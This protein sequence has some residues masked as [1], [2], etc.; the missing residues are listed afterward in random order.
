MFKP[1]Y[2]AFFSILFI[3][4]CASNPPIPDDQ[5]VESDPWENVNRKI[6]SFNDFFDQYLLVPVAKGYDFVTPKFIQARF[7]DFFKN[8]SEPWSMANNLLQLEIDDALLNLSRFIVNSTF[9]I[10]GLFDVATEVGMERNTENFGLTLAKW[11]VPKGNYIV[12]PFFGPS[13]VRQGTGS[14]VGVAAYDTYWPAKFSA[15]DDE[16]MPWNGLNRSE[17]V[18]LAVLDIVQLRADLLSLED[19][20]IGDKYTFIREAYLQRVKTQ[21]TDHIEAEDEEFDD[22]FEDEEEEDAEVAQ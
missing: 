11:G 15:Q 22:F 2:I 12:I 19:K 21:Q 5:L 16:T 1:I 10:F 3:I 18:G 6:Y 17:R 14:A 7:R 4:G 8:I 20:I 13:T 9:G